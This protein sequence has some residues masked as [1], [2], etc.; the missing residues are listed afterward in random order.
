MIVQSPSNGSTLFSPWNHS[1]TSML[2]QTAGHS[3]ISVF[4]F[5]F[6]PMILNTSRH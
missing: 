3:N 5:V 6:S 2:K 4:N 1:A